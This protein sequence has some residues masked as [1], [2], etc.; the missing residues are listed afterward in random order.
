M[1]ACERGFAQGFS[2][3]VDPSLQAS[4][5]QFRREGCVVLPAKQGAKV[6]RV[7]VLLQVVQVAL[8][9]VKIAHAF[10]EQ[11]G[12]YGHGLEGVFGG[13]KADGR[14]VGH[15]LH[16]GFQPGHHASMSGRAVGQHGR[17]G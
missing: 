14:V 4:V 9:K 15:V 16:G 13:I 12:V 5:G 1:R 11:R 8:A 10:D 2:A 6:I 3:A 17:I 7:D